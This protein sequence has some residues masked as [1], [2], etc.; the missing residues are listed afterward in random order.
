M[1]WYLL[2]K[3]GQTCQMVQEACLS[4]WPLLACSPPV[5]TGAPGWEDSQA[6]SS[7]PSLSASTGLLAEP[8][9]A[10]FCSLLLWLG[11]SYLSVLRP[12]RLGVSAKS[13][14]FGVRTSGTAS[15]GQYPQGCCKSQRGGPALCMLYG[16]TA[17]GSVMFY[18]HVQ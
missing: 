7:T 13:T 8:F 12:Q 17:S 15:Y 11:T 2:L 1:A 18:Y 10:Q 14:A 9:S 4:S 6:V 3:Q 16:V 5:G